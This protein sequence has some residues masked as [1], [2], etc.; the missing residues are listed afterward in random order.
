VLSNWN[1]KINWTLEAAVEGFFW[2]LANTKRQATRGNRFFII[3]NE[4]V[5]K[6]KICC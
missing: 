4:S 6:E 5:V 1:L 2:Q 3:G